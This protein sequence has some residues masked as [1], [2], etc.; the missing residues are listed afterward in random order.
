MWV[1]ISNAPG[2][3]LSIWLN[4]GAAKLQYQEIYRSNN[5]GNIGDVDGDGD[6]DSNSQGVSGGASSSRS[7]S[8]SPI[9]ASHAYGHAHSSIPSLT[10]HEHWVL[11]VTTIWMIVLAIAC[12]TPIDDT[13]HLDQAQFIG[14]VV[15]VNLIIFYGAPLS[16]IAAVL[17]ARDSVSIH[18]RTLGTL[19][20]HC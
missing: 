9:N 11:R 15:N 5:I 6:S 10:P 2:L 14:L 8:Y 17:R 13:I 4:M 3:I 18:R 20:C 1:L 16:T 12:F 19:Q 7:T